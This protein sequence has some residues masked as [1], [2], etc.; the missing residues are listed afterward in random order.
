MTD[1]GGGGSSGAIIIAIVIVLL[2][3]A[4]VI[5]LAVKRSVTIRCCTALDTAF[6]LLSPQHCFVDPLGLLYYYF[7]I[8]LWDLLA[9]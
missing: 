6:Y 8:E 4:A 2:T 3:L 5:F 1:G 7:G 9:C